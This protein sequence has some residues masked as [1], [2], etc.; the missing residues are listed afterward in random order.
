MNDTETIDELRLKRIDVHAA[1]LMERGTIDPP[2]TPPLEYDQLTA[3]V[4]TY[5]TGLEGERVVN[6][7]E[8]PETWWQAFKE[9]YAPDWFLRYF[10]VRNHHVEFQTRQYLA[11]C[12][13]VNMSPHDGDCVKFFIQRREDSDLQILRRQIDES[14]GLSCRRCG[15]VGHVRDPHS[16]TLQRCTWCWSTPDSVCNRRAAKFESLLRKEYPQEANHD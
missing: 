7:V 4:R 11:V 10:P 13:H 2:D 5:L 1:L 16:D 12:P 15:D 14:K 9:Q 6:S 3:K 8:Y